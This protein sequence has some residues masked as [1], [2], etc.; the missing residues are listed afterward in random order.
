MKI[1]KFRAGIAFLIFFITMPN[2]A[3]HQHKHSHTQIPLL[4]QGPVLD[5][6][7]GHVLSVLGRGLLENDT[8]PIRAKHLIKAAA[9]K[10]SPDPLA[11]YLCSQT[12]LAALLGFIPGMYFCALGWLN[13]S[14]SSAPIRIQQP[15]TYL[16]TTLENNSF[17]EAK[18]LPELQ[19]KA[20][21][22]GCSLYGHI[23]VQCPLGESLRWNGVP[24]WQAAY[25]MF[26][27][28]I[29]QYF[30][31]ER[32]AYKPWAIR[33]CY[34]LAVLKCI[35]LYAQ[36][37]TA[38]PAQY[39][40]FAANRNFEPALW[41]LITLSHQDN[42]QQK[43][44]FLAAQKTFIEARKQVLHTLK[45]EITDETVERSINDIS[46]LI[47]FLKSYSHY[48]PCASIF[49]NSYT[50]AIELLH[51]IIQSSGH[52]KARCI[53]ATLE[54][55]QPDDNS[56]DRAF[57]LL[58]PVVYN[59]QAQR[60][61]AQYINKKAYEKLVTC[62]QDNVHASFMLGIILCSNKETQ[63]EAY[64][65][66]N[67]GAQKKD[68][69]SLCSAASMIRKNFDKDKTVNDAV[70]YYTYAYT[71]APTKELQNLVLHILEH[72]AQEGCL[73]AHCHYIL[74][75]LKSPES[76]EKADMLIQT[77]EALHNKEFERYITYLKNN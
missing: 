3:M 11:L 56:I 45:T 52:Y 29:E 15:L 12:R 38:T 6:L 26:A 73:P 1:R 62:A 76:I 74:T 39:L 64:T 16:L 36:I 40:Y 31:Q 5:S 72:M 63:A 13:E 48:A 59:P 57:E 35:G 42:P 4:A 19:K 34:A 44:V 32:P 17:S 60:F 41:T 54:L 37:P 66:F 43:D 68:F 14:L 30:K 69:Y 25:L 67:I 7:N 23:P 75:L 55:E 47:D 18:M 10:P 61:F 24:S 49:T 65:Y 70:L 46:I 21:L 33:A 58:E 53:V 8:L 71:C 2:N 77:I 22:A 9:C 50:N 51:R 20:A 28:L 27:R